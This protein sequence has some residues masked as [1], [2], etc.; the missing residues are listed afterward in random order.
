VVK[1]GWQ[2]ELPQG[3]R[4]ENALYTVNAIETII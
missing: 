4:V 2:A 3:G 1:L